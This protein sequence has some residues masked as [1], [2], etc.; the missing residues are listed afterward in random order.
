MIFFQKYVC[1]DQHK[2]SNVINQFVVNEL[3]QK[4]QHN[5]TETLIKK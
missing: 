5:N 3:F 1:S 4:P 2:D